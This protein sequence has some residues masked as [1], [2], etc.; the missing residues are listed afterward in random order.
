MEINDRLINRATRVLALFSLW[1]GLV[2]TFRLLGVGSGNLNPLAQMGLASFVYHA[3]FALG[4]LFAAVG[5]WL[6]S[7]WGAVVLLA[8][9]LVHTLLALGGNPH[10][11]LD[12]AG[13]VV[14]I[15]MGLSAVGVLV[16]TRLKARDFLNE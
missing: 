7:S 9:V 2:E 14:R 13:L 12:A 8:I 1:L 5:L 11:S 10:V 15:F 4:L 3:A 16:W 6:L